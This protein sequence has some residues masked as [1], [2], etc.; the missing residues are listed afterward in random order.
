[1]KTQNETNVTASNEDTGKIRKSDQLFKTKEGEEII[2]PYISNNN[3]PCIIHI[4][5][6]S[7]KSESKRPD[8]MQSS[9]KRKEYSGIKMSSRELMISEN[10]IAKSPTDGL[11]ERRKKKKPCEKDNSS[12]L[13][14]R[15]KRNIQQ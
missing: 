7:M 3:R 10:Q 1:M 15:Q 2:D 8:G 6:E 4:R 11:R 13:A 12:N 9:D 5:S 14:G